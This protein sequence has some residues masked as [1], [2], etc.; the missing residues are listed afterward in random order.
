MEKYKDRFMK[1]VPAKAISSVWEVNHIIDRDTCEKIRRALPSGE[2]ALLYQHIRDNSSLTSIKKMCDLLIKT[3]D[4]GYPHVKKLGEDMK[5]E[6]EQL[7]TKGLL[8][9]S[10]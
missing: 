5:E 3:G 9:Y 7:L 1:Y 6:L 10:V 2:T 4:K 8:Q